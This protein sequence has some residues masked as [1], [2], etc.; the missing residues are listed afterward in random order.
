MVC[1]SDADPLKTPVESVRSLVSIDD[2]TASIYGYGE[3][4]VGKYN[5]DGSFVG[6]YASEQPERQRGRIISTSPNPR[7]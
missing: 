7:I 1:N 5:E 6:A 2:D 4:D 3:V